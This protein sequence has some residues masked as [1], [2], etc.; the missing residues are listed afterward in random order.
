MRRRD[1]R[2][3]PDHLQGGGRLQPRPPCKGAAGCSQVPY[4]G[5]PP[6][7]AAARKGWPPVGTIGYGQP[8]RGCRP[9][10]SRKGRSPTASPQ[11]PTARGQVARGGCPRR[12]YKVVAASGPLTASP[13]ACAGEATATAQK[14]NMGLGHPLEKRMIIPL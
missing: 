1:S 9:R 13:A 7:R 3:W 6:T 8:A 14:G 2:A 11:G 12:A 10:P 4:K 5:R